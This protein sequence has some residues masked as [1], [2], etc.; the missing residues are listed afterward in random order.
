MSHHLAR[1]LV[2]AIVCA[3]PSAALAQG[4]VL[5]SIVGNVYD[6]TGQ[7]LPGVKVVA[8]SP[9]HIG[10]RVAYSN[11]DGGFRFV[12]L[13]PGV[14]EV[15]SS[16]PK[17]A[18]V[19]QKGIK[20]GVNAAAEVSLVME[21]AG[22]VEE[23][24][25]VE[26]APIVSTTT[27]NVKEAWDEEF[28]D[29]LPLE[30]RTSVEELVGNATPGAVYAGERLV[31]IRGGNTEQN[32]YLLDGFNMTGFK[33]LYKS[34][35]AMEVSTAGY[36]A[37]GAI[38][39]GGLVT[40]VTKTGS[41]KYE[42]DVNGFHED[43]LLR[44]FTEARDEVPRDWRMYINPNFS[45]PI[46]KDKVWFFVNGEFRDE[47]YSRGLDPSGFFPR[48]PTQ[49]YWNYRATTKVTWQ[50]TPRNKVQHF[51]FWDINYSRNRIASFNTDNDAQSKRERNGIYNGVTWESLLT[52]TLFF[53]LQ[54]GH[55]LRQEA[56]APQQC[57]S[58]PDAC[59]HTPALVQTIPQT[60]N[61]QN[62][63]TLSLQ[64]INQIEAVSELQWF[65]SSK[66]LGE[67]SIKVQSRYFTQNQ[68]V[69]Q[70][71]PGDRILRIAG[72]VPDRETVFY[73]NDPRVEDARYGYAIFD[74][75]GSRWTSFIQDAARLTRYWTVTP[76]VAVTMSNSSNSR[77][78]TVTDGMAVTPHFSTAWD[79]THDGRTVLRA[80]FNQYVDPDV[81]RLARHSLG[82][83]V[84]R[85]C[86]WNASNGA[87][88]DSCVYSG[89]LPGSSVGSPC[90]PD[91][92]NPD[93]TDCRQKLRIPR[94]WEYTLGAEREVVPGLGVG[95]DFVFRNYTYPYATKETN[96]IW[97]GSGSALDPTG[98]H[99]NGRPER[100]IDLETPEDAERRYRGVTFA[101]HRRE[102]RLKLG[103]SYTWSS[104]YG[105]SFDTETNAWG[106][107][108][109]RDRL[110][111][112]PMPDDARHVVKITMNYQLVSWLSTGV[113]YSFQ[114]GRPYSRWFHN[115]QTGGY[116]DLRAQVGIN[117]GS[118]INDP[119][120]DR[121]ARLPDIQ[122]F[123]LQLRANLRPLTG[124]QI[125]LY[126]DI[127]NVFALRTTTSVVTEDG[128]R[129]G[130]PEGTMGPMLIRLG[131][132]YRF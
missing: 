88:T 61:L 30:T 35:G 49:H 94:T 111:W 65:L 45:G 26:K 95:I 44:A 50:V 40:M 37:D 41:N 103:A 91:G 1:A 36:G 24:K 118:N 16:A 21:V 12:A 128:P 55:G 29:N 104:T 46:I 6:Q 7:P 33:T 74:S 125:E 54:A 109:P 117:P 38:A 106:D 110:L 52:D 77:G 42:F 78:L 28:I 113:L 68:S 112:G 51:S 67:H 85:E 48:R 81:G 116:D 121:E 27:A 72:D 131:F 19:H 56:Q 31:R 120:D 34:L 126:S 5:G 119:T 25:V 39:P 79:A 100:I 13:Q 99:R 75:T 108:P 10:E 15:I 124:Q 101:L 4:G 14:F 58:D 129:F 62:W 86:R 66:S 71:T 107:I 96:Q 57:L 3:A 64:T 83:R 82:T 59:L 132:R 73:S 122:A 87:Y 98:T 63:N 93:G 130:Q 69:A 32:L 80:S 89:G 18:S 22:T 20:V 123:N 90:G 76:G 84:S 23:V 43:S 102:G 115:T 60:I 53:K 114:S 8:K 11:A 2:V 105:N 17:M 70:G 92:V 47:R 9:T 97:N 127:Q